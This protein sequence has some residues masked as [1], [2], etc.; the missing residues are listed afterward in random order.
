MRFCFCVR[1]PEYHG[2]SHFDAAAWVDYLRRGHEFVKVLW[3]VALCRKYTRALTFLRTGVRNGVSRRGDEFARYY[4]EHGM[5][6]Y[7]WGLRDP[8]TNSTHRCDTSVNSTQTLFLN[9]FTYFACFYLNTGATRV[10]TKT[11][12]GCASGFVIYIY[13]TYFAC[14]TWA[15]SPLRVFGGRYGAY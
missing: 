14:F 11:L 5:T 1:H 12:A 3:I 4:F 8:E 10:H 15:Q 6:M 13:F 9:L 2:R 7:H